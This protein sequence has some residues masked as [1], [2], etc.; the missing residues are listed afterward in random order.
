VVIGH[1]A[2]KWAL[3][4]VLEGAPLAELVEASF[5]RQPGWTYVLH[6]DS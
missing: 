6:V 2:T 1:P 4:H 5:H 3:D